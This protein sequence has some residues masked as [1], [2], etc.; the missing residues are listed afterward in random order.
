MPDL[1]RVDHFLSVDLARSTL[2]LIPDHTE[3]SQCYYA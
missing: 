2:D 1:I 3:H